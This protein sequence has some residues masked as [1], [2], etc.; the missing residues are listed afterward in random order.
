MLKSDWKEL[1]DWQNE[2][3]YAFLDDA[4]L[5]VWVWEFLRRSMHYRRYWHRWENCRNHDKPVYRPRK[6]VDESAEQW[7]RRI[8]LEQ[9]IDAKPVSLKV[10]WGRA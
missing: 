2:T 8:A 6:R 5:E 7:W 4:P 3:D 9:N 10:H 1:P